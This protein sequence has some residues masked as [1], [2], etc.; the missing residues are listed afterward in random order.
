MVTNYQ[1]RTKET[2][3]GICPPGYEKIRGYHK[4]DGTYVPT[5]CRRIKVDGRA[6]TLVSGVYNEVRIAG[7]DAVLGTETVFDMPE[8]AE[9]EAKK[10]EKRSIK[11]HDAMQE[12]SEKKRDVKTKENLV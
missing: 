11:V 2:Y 5:H 6:H 7:E 4:S 1:V 9:K 8:K 12:Q 3:H 10:I